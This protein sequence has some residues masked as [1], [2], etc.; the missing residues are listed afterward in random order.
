MRPGMTLAR[1]QT[2]IHFPL[3]GPTMFYD[4]SST[5]SHRPGRKSFMT[6]AAQ[7]WHMLAGLMMQRQTRTALSGLNDHLLKDIGV[8]RGEIDRISHSATPARFTRFG[9]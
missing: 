5:A 9:G 3:Q 8:S 7:P 6:I 1:P 2:F 4:T